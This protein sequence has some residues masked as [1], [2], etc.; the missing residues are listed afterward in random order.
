MNAFCSRADGDLRCCVALRTEVGEGPVWDER[1]GTLYWIDV[2][3]E[4]LFRYDPKTQENESFDVGQAVGSVALCSGGGLLLALRDGIATFDLEA[5]ELKF[6]AQP[7]ADQ[8]EKH[9]NDGACDPAG[10]FW[11]GTMAF[12]AEAGA[13]GLYRLDSDLTCE[14]VLDGF[15]IPNGLCWSA[16]G[17]TMYH[18]D[19]V[20]ATVTAYDY[21]V[22][23]GEVSGA[24]VIIE[25]DPSMGLPD[26]MTID[27]E[28]KLWIAHYG[29]SCVRR[30][31]PETGSVLQKI[32]VPASRVTA[33]AFGGAGLRRLYI[34]TATQEMDEEELQREPKAGSLFDVVPGVQG[35]PVHRFAG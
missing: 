15:T 23:A 30:W 16:D 34:T 1:M 9:S 25:V 14:K 28:G 24:E 4:K 13:G 35:Q 26:D 32:D 2:T 22:E 5:R 3:G 18:V 33:C 29:G 17:A 11:V 12:S 27:T 10:R 6:V 20:P 7:E 31:D 8:L 21:D 19:S